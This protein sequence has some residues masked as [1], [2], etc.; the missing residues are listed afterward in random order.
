MKDGPSGCAAY[1]FALSGIMLVCFFDL[2]GG[3]LVCFPRARPTHPQRRA[4]SAGQ[5]ESPASLAS[6]GILR[7]PIFSLMTA[8]ASGSLLDH[9]SGRNPSLSAAKHTSKCSESETSLIIT[10]THVLI[11]TRTRYTHEALVRKAAK[12]KHYDWVG[13]DGLDGRLQSSKGERIL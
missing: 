4:I 10:C 7:T 13:F 9:Y 11:Y 6:F 5:F 12:N 8:V 2:G 1:S 3:L